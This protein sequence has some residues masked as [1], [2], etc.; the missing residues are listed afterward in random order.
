MSRKAVGNTMASGV[1][2]ALLGQGARGAR[3]RPHA[4]CFVFYSGVWVQTQLSQSR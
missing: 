4:A 3:Q 1:S 2:E